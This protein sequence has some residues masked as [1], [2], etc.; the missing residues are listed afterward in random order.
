[1]SAHIEVGDGKKKEHGIE[2]KEA[3]IGK[4]R[5]IKRNTYRNKERNRIY[6]HHA[7]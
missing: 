1:M 5:R 2:V 7:L 6:L 3:E 4:N